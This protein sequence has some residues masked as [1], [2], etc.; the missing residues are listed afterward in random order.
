MPFGINI[1]GLDFIEK[2]DFTKILSS[3]GNFI[4]ILIAVLLI[5]GIVIFYLYRRG[6]A[7]KYNKTLHFFEEVNG[8]IVPVEDLKGAEIT[9]PNTNI[10]VFYVKTKD[11]YL[12]RAT[13]RM[14]KN[15]FWYCVR[16]NREIINFRMR[17]INKETAEAGLDYDHTDM[18]YAQNN[19]REIIKRNFRDKSIKWWLAY[20][21]TIA[22]VVFIF[23]MG[24]A[25][26]FLLSKIASLVGIVGEL[27]DKVKELLNIVI[28]NQGSGL[29][30]G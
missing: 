3:V 19:L 14:G 22:I 18:R 24:L 11:M 16:N 21:D 26:W 23:V 2:I 9:I 28:Q 7:K 29:K 8:E 4:L 17:N 27:I 13:I 15:R 12:P 30:A 25:F 20:K 5:G 10:T 6:E 1:P